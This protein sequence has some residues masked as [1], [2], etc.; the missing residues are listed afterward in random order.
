MAEDPKRYDVRWWDERAQR[1]GHVQRGPLTEREATGAKG[2]LMA[3]HEKVEII[4]LED[5]KRKR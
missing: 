1:W 3:L 2:I 4:E 5:R